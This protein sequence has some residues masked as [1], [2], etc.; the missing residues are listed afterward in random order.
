MAENNNG[1]AFKTPQR[2][3]QIKQGVYQEWY[4]DGR[5]VVYRIEH[6]DRDIVASWSD[7]AIE[8]IRA[9]DKA[10]PY[11]AIHDLSYPGVVMR[12]SMLEKSIMN[13]AVTEEGQKKIEDII[14]PTDETAFQARVAIVVSIQFSGYLAR[15][16][17]ELEAIS[18]RSNH[19]KYQV[20]TDR[21]GALNWLAK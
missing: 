2:I 5:I 17:A 16:F 4:E 15:T 19:I 21:A 20:F 6:I 8:T 10:S 11:L 3:D 1:I 12:L 13:L 7:L 9:W 14:V 18:K